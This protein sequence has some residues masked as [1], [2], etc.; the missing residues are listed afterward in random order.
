MNSNDHNAYEFDGI[1]HETP[2]SGGAYVI[3]PWDLRKEFGK[4][5]VKVYA[6][7]DGLPY[8]GFIVNMGLTDPPHWDPLRRGQRY[9][10]WAEPSQW[11]VC[12]PAYKTLYTLS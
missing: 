7:F 5:R 11:T 9:S 3:F 8:E 1:I 2:E 10:S 12:S 6:E 4:G